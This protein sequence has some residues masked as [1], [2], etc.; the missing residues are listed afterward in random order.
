MKVSPWSLPSLPM[1]T[2]LPIDEW[3]PSWGSFAHFLEDDDVAG[4]AAAFMLE[5]LDDGSRREWT[6]GEWRER[7]AETAWWLEEHGIAAE[8]AIAVLAGN[9]AYA[10][11]VAFACWA[12]GWVYVPLNADESTKRLQFVLHH[13]RA[14][15]LLHVDAMAAPARAAGEA[16][17]TPTLPL[18]SVG[19]PWRVTSSGTPWTSPALRV[20]TSGTTGEPK[21]VELTTG[22]LITDC[23]A[24][25]HASG[26]GPESRALVVL[27]IHHVNGLVV[28]CLQAWFVGGSVVL[29][30]RFRS[31][32]FLSIAAKERVTTSS[33]VPTILE[34][35]LEGDGSSAAMTGF[36]DVFCGAGPLMT[37][38]VLGF[39]E[40]FDLP[41]RH[42]YG[43]SETTAVA[44]MIPGD[45]VAES[46]KSWYHDHGFP[47]VGKA[48]P[49]VALDVHDA[50]G[51]ACP[52]G[53]RGEIVIRGATVM[54]G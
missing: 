48:V 6:R 38:T 25:R 53:Q 39:E 43:L 7:V 31:D 42:L 54:S 45:L 8:S 20:Y 52:S 13:A 34:F 21:G 11:A 26:W 9:S 2:S 3:A 17:G 41:V 16:S 35:L 32:T 47:S 36:T 29:C 46:R 19:G 1:T 4:P 14:Q 5:L 44:T 49:H 28:S 50:D 24:L 22:N 37:E 23:D 10:L 33:L 27:P 51:H 12:H 30:E 15:I 18:S 40:R